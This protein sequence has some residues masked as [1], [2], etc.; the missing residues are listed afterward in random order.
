MY[1]LTIKEVLERF[2]VSAT[3]GM[4]DDQVQKSRIKH[5]VNEITPPKKKSLIKRIFEA[6]CDPMLL[7][8][9][10]AGVIT[11]GVNLGKTFAGQDGNFYECLGIFIAIV[12]SVSLTVIME[13]RSKRAFDM[14][15]KLSNQLN[16]KVLRKGKIAYVSKSEVVVGDVVLLEAG[17]K[18][19]ADGRL[20]ESIALSVDESMLT[21]ESKTVKKH[22]EI[23]LNENVSLAERINMV[24]SGTFVAEGSGVMVVTAVGDSAEMGL[25]AKDL[26]ASVVVS[27]PLQ[28]KLSRLG[29]TISLLGGI[30]A[31]F[32]F[33]LSLVRLITLGEVTFSSIQNLFIEAIILIVAAVPEGLPSTMAI[34]LTLNVLRLAK[35]N[36]LIKKLVATETVGCVSV[37]CSDKTGTLTENKMTVEQVVYYKNNTKGENYVAL[38]S[39]INSTAELIKNERK[40][41][42]TEVAL[43]DFFKTSVDYRKHRKENQIVERIPFSSNVK[44]MQTTVGISSPITFLKG[45]P[46]VILEKCNLNQNDK[47]RL[48][49]EISFYQKQ[50]KRVIA[51][52]H[53]KNGVSVFDGYAV[54]SDKIRDE[55]FKAVKTC[56]DAGIKVK[57]LTGD[58]VETAL[59]I[60][61]AIGI[62]EGYGKVVSGDAIDKMSDEQLLSCI[63]EVSVVARSTPKVK[64][65]VVRALQQL[66]EVVAVTGDGV[67]DAPAVKHADIGIAMGS[68]SEITKEASDIV[69]LD[70]CF[71]TIITAIS[72]G[73]NIFGNFQR[74]IMFQLTVNLSSMCIIIAYLLMGLQSPFTSTGLLWLN[75]IMDG[76]LA[77]S[78]GLEQRKADFLEK[79]PIKRS[80]NILSVKIMLRIVLHAAFVGA[81][82]VLQELYNFLGCEIYQ[83]K[84]VTFAIFVV[85]QLFNAINCRE[86]R[87]ITAFK[88]IFGN[89]LLLLA[90]VLTFILQIIITQRVPMFFST[91]PLSFAL[92]VKITVLCSLI[93]AFS[94]GYKFVIRQMRKTAE[95]KLKKAI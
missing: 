81:V 61:N 58:N 62:G 75:I 13:G 17:D 63:S 16:V 27:A 1:N 85:F 34:S 3:Q 28:E 48:T 64:L 50:T 76:P 66:G 88:G 51:F 68:G 6:V 78:L 59:S 15:G 12:V 45:A 32:V 67:N 14:L 37:I 10:V 39:A 90:G 20:I 87:E 18:I 21:G 69:L 43:I 72:F 91:A 54:L 52:M 22:A 30:S 5:G 29:K 35:S 92:W 19:V 36:A 56:L 47:I 26:K 24:Y 53:V 11:F 49:N 38:N 46:E 65:K 57:M 94:E 83:K 79:K 40:G 71:S 84:T 31:L 93:I 89:K 2:N 42:E 86:I 77:L 9:V 82:V 8:L 41:S 25:L 80:D 95:P 55:V 73:R 4:N 33:I 60:A 74:F 23:T 7:I 70:N 44:Y